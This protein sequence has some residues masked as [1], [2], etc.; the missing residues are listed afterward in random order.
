MNKKKKIQDVLFFGLI[1]FLQF[2]FFNNA[3]KINFFKDDFFFLNLSHIHKL[4]EFINFFSP[5]RE[6]SFK[7]LA[8]EVFYFLITRFNNPLFIGHLLGFIIFFTGLI[9]LY[10]NFKILFKDIWVPKITVLL[11]TI[12]YTHVFQLYWLATFQEL[13]LFTGLVISFYYYLK[14]K[15]T[16]SLV[17]FTVALLSKET[18]T[19][20]F[21]FLIL[22]EFIKS[23]VL[24]RKNKFEFNKLIKY[25][26][27]TLIFYLIYQYSLK[28]VTSL[29]NY[30]LQFNNPKLLIN[31]AIWYLLWSL[32]A[33]LFMP[34]YLPSLFSK[35]IPEFYKYLSVPEFKLF[36]YFFVSYYLLLLVGI[37]YY[38]ILNKRKIVKT[39]MLSIVCLIFFYCFLGPIL[40]FQHKWILRLIVPLIFIALVQGFLLSSFFQAQ[41]SLLK[42]IAVFLLVLYFLWNFFATKVHE[43]A[44]T[45]FLE[46]GIVNNTLKK[47]DKN[48]TE[49]LKHKYVY[50]KDTL[51]GNT[52]PW[53]GSEKLKVTYWGNSFF[54]YYFGN[55]N[56]KPI[57][58]FENK[59]IPKDS[60]II[61]SPKIL[62]GE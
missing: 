9:Y 62:I 30:R 5:V 34:D 7:P 40:L 41:K 51:V 1:A 42:I 58:S 8:S 44:S 49:I 3:F 17:F 28:Y 31:N 19:L 54:K 22:Y 43:S 20:F 59:I 12:S 2:F 21:P 25:F 11:F 39:L 32:G 15:T 55:L 52:N 13:F 45:Y 24:N 23:R 47:F 18:A 33:P 37:V 38:F 61:E 35:P 36:I 57:Y 26:F 6:Y 53:G 10:K 60:Y 56:I 50:F 27:I 14:E 29:D 46:T 48:K 4:S 16:L